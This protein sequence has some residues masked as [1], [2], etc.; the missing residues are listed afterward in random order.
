MPLKS[1]LKV[2]N[3]GMLAVS[4]FYVI[5][6]VAEILILAFSD[7]KLVH[8]APLAVLG[9]IAAYGLIAGK[10]W[11]IMLAIILFFPATTFGATALYASIIRHTFSASLEILLLHLGLIVYLILSFIA[12]MFVVAVRKKFE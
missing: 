3:L 10:K 9:L 5:V 12:L 1:K 4:V 6:G 11:A 7:F 8:V 2:E